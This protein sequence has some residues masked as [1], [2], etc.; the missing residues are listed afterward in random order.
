VS[1]VSGFPGAEGHD[2]RRDRSDPI[3]AATAERLL[4]GEGGPRRLA[5]LLSAASAPARW[6]ELAGEDAAAAVFRSTRLAPTRRSRRRVAV[7]VA[8]ARLISVKAAVLV[9][10]LAVGGVALAAGTG[11][12]PS[13]LRG[14]GSPTP[15]PAPTVA[16]SSAGAS[17]AGSGD[18]RTQPAATGQAPSASLQG[19]CRAYLAVASGN[20][21]QELKNPMFGALVAAAGGEDQVPTYCVAL[22]PEPTPKTDT[23]PAKPGDHP[24]GPP[25]SR[26]TPHAT[27]PAPPGRPGQ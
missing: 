9:L 7:R 24:T 26:S 13:P 20:P 23:G 11:V 8:W 6:T 2:M 1:N 22:V 19:L 12:I 18:G 14:G 21:H 27:V 17:T 3:D 10:V 15:T 25:T 5:E 4:A 16:V